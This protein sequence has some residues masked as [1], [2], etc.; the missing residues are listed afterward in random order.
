MKRFIQLLILCFSLAFFGLGSYVYAEEIEPET[1]P[2]AETETIEETETA[3]PCQVKFDKFE[4]G[5]ISVS[6]E[7]GEIGDIVELKVKGD[8]LY[9]INSVKVNGTDLIESETESGTYSFA[10][11]EGDNLIEVEFVVDEELCGALTEIVKEATEKDWTNLFTVENVLTIIKWLFDGGILF[12][13][14]RYFIRDKK[15]ADKVEK[16]VKDTL[17]GIIPD[18]TKNAVIANSKSAIEPIFKQILE[19]ST[20]V[21]QT[22]S[23]VVKSMILMQ[24]GTPEAKI[25]IL[26]EFEKLKGITDVSSIANVK[27]YIDNQIEAHDKAFRETLERL[28]NIT[29]YH[30]EN[31]AAEENLDTQ[32]ELPVADNGTQI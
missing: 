27:K 21:R 11:V 20:L 16:I 3:K 25:A 28:N 1:P 26:D 32:P 4:H 24:Q 29:E 10:L 15:L 5:E 30:Q 9:K 23:I 31:V 17:E 12:A 2:A 14:I 6:A 8:L 13:M 7:D 18:T 22:M 19:D